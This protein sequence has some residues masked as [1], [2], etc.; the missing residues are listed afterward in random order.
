M[1]RHTYGRGRRRLD[2]RLENQIPIDFPAAEQAAEV[3]ALAAR[4]ARI[5]KMTRP[6]I[7][8]IA[9]VEK[10]PEDEADLFRRS[11]EIKACTKRPAL[12][13]LMATVLASRG[14]RAG[15]ELN[16][17]LDPRL[18][19]ELG[20]VFSIKGMDRFC[21]EL[22]MAIED[23]KKICLVHDYDVDGTSSAA[24][25]IRFLKQFPSVGIRS[26][27][28][29][30]FSGG[31]GI[32]AER[33]GELAD[34]GHDVF[35]FLDF[36]TSAHSAVDALREQGKKVLIVDHHEPGDTL[37]DAD[38]FINPKQ[39]G[40]GA[41]DM[42]PCTGGLSFIAML[43]LQQRLC[44]SFN[45]S[46]ASIAYHSD[47]SPMLALAMLATDADVVPLQKINRAI[48]RA[49]KYHLRKSEYPWAVALREAAGILVG[50]IVGADIGFGLGPRINAAGRLLDDGADLVVKLLTTDDPEEAKA[51]ASRLNE[52][53]SERKEINKRDEQ[54][55]IVEAERQIM[56]R[57]ELP[58]A[59]VIANKEFH[60][61]VAGIVA[62][63]IRER[64]NRPTFVLAWNERENLWSGSGRSIDS[65]LVSLK[66]LLDEP[67]VRGHLIRAGGHTKAAGLTV[68]DE[69]LPAFSAALDAAVAA[70]IRGQDITPVV[71][72]DIETSLI[73]LN[74]DGLAFLDESVKVLEPCGAGNPS[75]RVLI[76]GVSVASVRDP[77]GRD[78]SGKSQHL[79][80]K[81][82]DDRPVQNSAALAPADRFMD[83]LFWFQPGHPPIRPGMK[84]NIVAELSR[85]DR[86]AGFNPGAQKVQLKIVALEEALAGV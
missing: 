19:R 62:A 4:A 47:L 42:L 58:S 57:G 20:G 41:L 15:P 10:S 75:L 23:G 52:L 35:L 81:L 31:Y 37:P 5:E 3:A 26:E 51:L 50:R 54:L 64:F 21:D 72:W 78:A 43:G 11:G 46:I 25:F 48:S 29:R 38:A 12:S 28:S 67:E 60:A 27:G 33:V 59:F 32:G 68:S 44:A 18:K 39:P 65:D 30:R 61:G 80:I 63:R 40:C 84:V 53:N 83:G 66:A 16:R 85:D 45:E 36:G 2:I 73:E 77:K 55:A 6:V 79:Q 74:R 69:N 8:S 13:A 86:Y 9:P 82:R 1:E 17:F 76:R 7:G 49:G 70:R 24:M 22:A 14:H 34:E 56:E 71:R